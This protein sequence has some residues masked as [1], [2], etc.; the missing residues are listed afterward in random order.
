MIIRQGRNLAKLFYLIIGLH[1]LVTCSMVPTQTHDTELYSLQNQRAANAGL[2]VLALEDVDT[3]IKLDNDWLAQQFAAVLKAQS[4][5]GGVYRFDKI[6]TVFKNQYIHLRTIVEIKDEKGNTISAAL[7]GD[8]LLNYSGNGLEWRPRFNQLQIRSKNFTFSGRSYNEPDA[9]LTQT[10]LQNLNAVLVKAVIENDSN[11]IPLNPVPLGKIQLGASLPGFTESNAETT[12]SLRGVFMIAGSAV[13]IDSS[14]TSIALDL[15][16]IPDL[17]TCPA[18]VTVSRA[19]FVKDI[20]SREPV[21]IA[22]DINN[23]AD[24]GYFYS[25]IAG[26]KRPLTIIHYWFAD[27]LPMVVEELEVG[28]SERWRTWSSKGGT[29]SNA[30]QWEVLVVEKESGCILASKSI[31]TL[32]S[33]TPITRV[34]QDQARQTFTE[35]QNAFSGRTSGFSINN[36]KPG[37]ALIEV[38][39]PFLQDVL[40]ASLSDLSIDAEFDSSGFSVLPFSAKIQSFDAE[41][42]MC[43]RRVCSPTPV[44]K[45]SLTQCKRIRDTRD[46]SSCQFRNP[47]NNR[48]VSEAVDP[49]CE[50][51][52][53]RQN[54]R[55]EEE[56]RICVTRA[57]NEKR[58]CDRLNAQVFSSCRIEAGFEESTCESVKSGLKAIKRGTPLALFNTQAHSTG[59]LSVNFSNFI[60]KDDL[61]GLMLDMSLQSGL[62]LD[63]KLNFK[64]VNNKLPLAKCIAE[65]SVPFSS[66]FAGAPVINSMLGKL[67]QEPGMLTAYWSGIGIT[68]EAQPSPLESIFVGNPQ[69]LANC[70]IGLTVSDVEQAV[71]GGD[72]AF[73]RGQTDLIIQAIPT[74]IHL[75]PASIQFGNKVYSANANLTAQ[76]LQYDIRE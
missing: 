50:A 75:A 46:C 44:C 3:L 48:C 9:E 25:E 67:E 60:I 13:L 15:A 5:L 66:R 68:I 23:P 16:F 51:A 72:A 39:R 33:E 17:S 40:Q 21:D 4:A 74:K 6:K 61:A 24:V 18:D 55:Y 63:G 47:L 14:V 27:G 57:E 45:T 64:P 53:N 20:A 29:N 42:V 43:E 10:T 38:R 41:N 8:I 52:R 70:H 30:A 1:V 31:H 56:R 69:L 12:Q 35:L 73:F 76:H 22:G 49:L 19:E 26:A 2:A 37:I 71:A 54:A 7:S 32:E 62:Q 34:S 28:P 11:T 59:K 65:W 58:E 36:D